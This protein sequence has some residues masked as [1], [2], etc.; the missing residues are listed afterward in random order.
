MQAFRK[1]TVELSCPV[2]S[3]EQSQL[4]D[5]RDRFSAVSGRYERFRPEYPE[6][7][8]RALATHIAASPGSADHPTIDIGCGTGIFTRQLARALPAGFRVIGVEPAPQM[9]R[10]AIDRSADLAITFTDGTAEALPIGDGGARAIVTATAAH[11]FDRPRFYA[12]ASRALPSRGVLA[13]VE[14]IR[15]AVY[16]PA[17]AAVEDFL[18]REG[19]PKA[20]MRPDYAA[21]LEALEE[22]E[23][24]DVL[25]QTLTLPLDMDGFVGLA[26]S[27][28]HA[29]GVLVRLGEASAISALLAIGMRLADGDGT[30]A[31]GYRFQAFIADRF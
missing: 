30:I 12:E 7:M 18:A 15:D 23:L 27:S 6:A 11:W 4:R 10:A 20:Y 31:Y 2:M 1:V 19:P 17:A 5:F 21:E 26:L 8:V 25:T 13:I 22:F 16:S 28:S 24:K 3:G 29:K 14:Y 9:R